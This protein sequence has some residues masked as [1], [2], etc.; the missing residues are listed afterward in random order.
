MAVLNL[1][2]SADGVPDRLRS[3][4]CTTA[5]ALSELYDNISTTSTHEESSIYINNSFRAVDAS[6]EGSKNSL[7]IVTN[8]QED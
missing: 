2:L 1:G 3:D 6:L 4:A 7:D 5:S 8:F